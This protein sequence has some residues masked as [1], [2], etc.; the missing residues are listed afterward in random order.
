M[1]AL[2]E[3]VRNA[4]ENA[5]IKIESDSKYVINALTKNRK[6]REDQGYIGVANKDLDKATVAGLR[7]RK[8][9]AKMKWVKGHSGHV[10][11]EGADRMADE[12]AKKDTPDE[13]NMEI[14]PELKLTGAK[15][16]AMTQ[17]QAYRA[18]REE[19]TKAKMER[20]KAEAEDNYGSIPTEEKIWKSFQCKDLSKQCQYFLWMITHDAYYVGTHWLRE[21]TSPEMQERGI[22]KHCDIPET[23]EH[24]LSQCEAPG[25][26]EIWELAKEL[27][28]KRN[29]DWAWPGIGTIITSRLATFKNEEG[30]VKAGDGRLYRLIMA[31]SAYLIWKLRCERVIQNN[32]VHATS[33]EIH[34][35]WVATMNP[36]L[37]LDCKMTDRMFEKKAIPVKKVLHTWKGILKGEDK[38]PDD[39]TGSAEVLVGI[40]PRRQQEE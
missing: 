22:C 5:D 20:A 33:K 1:V 37:K 31:E 34:N 27:W 17:S 3:A 35:R 38:L 32:G 23:M 40:E 13:V 16:S 24:I 14:P 28:L 9:E 10:R 21:G 12:G 25:Q 30:K 4:D 7:Q 11:N 2:K 29:P 6:K 36:R 19:R 26:G 39:W 18:I 8:R 15:L